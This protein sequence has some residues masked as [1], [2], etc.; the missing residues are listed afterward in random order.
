MDSDDPLRRFR[1]TR[2]PRCDYDLTGLPRAHR[3]PECGTEYD[4]DSLLLPCRIQKVPAFAWSFRVL[5][6]TIMVVGVLASLVLAP[7]IAAAF[8][9]HP[10]A[11]LL[12]GVIAA[13][14]AAAWI[15]RLVT[16]RRLKPDV[17]LI[18]T[19]PTLIV[20][21]RIPGAVQDKA[22]PSF[23]RVRVRRAGR[24]L[25]KLVL[26]HP[27]GRWFLPA[28]RLMVFFEASADEA[29]AVCAAIQR[30]IDGRSQTGAERSPAGRG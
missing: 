22:W 21:W 4:Q 6:F 16:G 12:L 7:T 10:G 27:K 26:E 29:K 14:V 18:I 30:H 5:R 25:R 23:N 28:R 20:R 2:C 24:R 9:I 1:F 17:A 15:P 13:A 19:P 8:G 3:C 11:L